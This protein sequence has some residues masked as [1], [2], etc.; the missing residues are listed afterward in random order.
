MAILEIN[1]V[2]TGQV[3]NDPRR[4]TITCTDNFATITAAG[5][6]NPA[7]AMG[8]TISPTDEVVVSYSS[9]TSSYAL[10]TFSVSIGAGTGIITLVAAD[11]SVVLPTVI[12]DFAVF[13]NVEGG[14]KDSSFSPTN[15][16]KTKV[17]MANAATIANHIA[18]ATDTAGTIGVDAATAING[19]N[20][21]AGLSGTAG[22]L[23]SFPATSARGS[24]KLVAVANSADNATTIS[25]ASMLQASTITIPDPGLSTSKFVLQ[26]SGVK[27]MISIVLTPTNINTMYT[28]PVILI[29]AVSGSI[30]VLQTVTINYTY[31]AAFAAGG[32]IVIQYGNTAPGAGTS[33]IAA[34]N[35]GA[36]GLLT[37]TAS[38]FQV[39]QGYD[40]AASGSG[41][42]LTGFVSTD[43]YISNQTQVFSGGAG[44][45]V[46]VYLE[47]QV[48]P[49]A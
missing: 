12:G 11:S 33:A 30:T 6:L 45:S 18:V 38:S 31:A 42:A 8:Y 40:T 35:A 9:G 47:Y 4:V 24:L 16:T 17:V 2:S 5:Y 10:Q 28:T 37:G 20:I 44:S 15:A 41:T 46:T 13:A 32:V 25:N 43:I 27:K 22:T 34:A 23:A 21:Q 49:V 7:N 26:N 1:T 29:P 48:Y 39:Q 19:G 36:A 3:G 14:L